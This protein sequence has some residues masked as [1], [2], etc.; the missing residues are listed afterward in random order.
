MNPSRPDKVNPTQLRVTDISTPEE[1]STYIPTDVLTNDG[2]YT[3]DL[4][5]VYR[6]AWKGEGGFVAKGLRSERFSEVIVRGENE[7]EVRT[8]EL[9]G[10]VLAKT[11]KWFYKD[12]LNQRFEDWAT[13]LKRFCEE[14]AKDRT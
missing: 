13:D 2:T 14:K 12:T 6:I 4:G 11:V 9:M 7:C 8:W 10:G 5:N 1:R 3:S